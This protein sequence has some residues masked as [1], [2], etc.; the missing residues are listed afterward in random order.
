[1][2]NQYFAKHRRVPVN[3][4]ETKLSSNLVHFT[5][6]SLSCQSSIDPYDSSSDDEQ[7][8]RPDHVDETTPGQSDLAAHLLTADRLYLNSPSEAPKHWGQI[9]PN[10]ND[11]HSN[12]MEISSTFWIPD[13]TDWWRQ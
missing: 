1:V 5:T 12:P 11:Y 4:L 3:K 13:M 7:Y 9:N 6:A 10:L 2:E 8:L